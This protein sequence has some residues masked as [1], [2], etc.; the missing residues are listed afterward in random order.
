M[1]ARVLYSP[2]A[3]VAGFVVALLAGATW[4]GID[5]LQRIEHTL[6]I[7]APLLDRQTSWLLVEIAHLQSATRR[8]RREQSAQA[9]EALSARLDLAWV[10]ADHI[11]FIGHEIMFPVPA[12]DRTIILLKR[13]DKLLLQGPAIDQAALVT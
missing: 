10:R 5:R 1:I 7:Q 9:A 8:M 13:L 4:Y 12:V 6:A 3:A 11:S 2:F